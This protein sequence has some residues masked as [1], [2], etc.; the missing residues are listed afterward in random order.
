MTT[1]WGREYSSGT[2]HASHGIVHRTNQVG[3]GKEGILPFGHWGRAGV[4]GRSAHRDIPLFD[5]ENAFDGSNLDS[6]ILEY[7][8]LFDV[9][10]EI[11]RELARL[12]AR[13]FDAAGVAANELD[14][15]TQRFSAQ[16]GSIQIDL[17]ESS[18]H[19]GASVQPTLLVL[20]DDC[21][22]GVAG[23]E[24]PIRHCPRALERGKCSQASVEGASVRNGVGVRPRSDRW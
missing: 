9:Q 21:L 15:L 18:C 16:C 20:E 3:G 11:R 12:P 22:K 17:R 5:P 19:G 7:C 10:F 4:V 8:T 23:Y 6:T 13:I 14:T 24:V 1:S 2:F